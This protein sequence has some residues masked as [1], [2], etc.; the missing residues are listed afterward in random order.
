MSWV[1]IGGVYGQ[2]T[3]IDCRISTTFWQP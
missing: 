2:V 3:G 1:A